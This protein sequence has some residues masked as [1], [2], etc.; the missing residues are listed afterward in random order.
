M[1]VII[2]QHRWPGLYKETTVTTKTLTSEVTHI[3]KTMPKI[4]NKG[5]LCGKKSASKGH[6]QVKNPVPGVATFL[7]VDRWKAP[8]VPNSI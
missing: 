3:H 4:L 1:A 2:E 6:K 5:T 8:E 7:C